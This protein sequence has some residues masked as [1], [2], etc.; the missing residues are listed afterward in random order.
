MK[1]L[2]V[3]LRQGTVAFENLK[4]EW[5]Y[6]GGSALIAKILNREVPPTA[7]P[8]GPE[9]HPLDTRLLSAAGAEHN[10]RRAV[11]LAGQSESAR[12]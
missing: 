10:A 3:D 6:L 11:C 4:E 12:R 8:L 9:N 5:Q 2:R 1:I 7:D